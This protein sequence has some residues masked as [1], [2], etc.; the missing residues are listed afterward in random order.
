[1]RTREQTP[2]V[3]TVAVSQSDWDPKVNG[4]RCPAL[5][6]PGTDVA[7]VF[8]AGNRVDKACYFVWRENEMI[9]WSH[10]PQPKEATILFKLTEALSTKK[11]TD[12]WKG[13]AA[14]APV[15]AALTTVMLSY[16][17]LRPSVN[18]SSGDSREPVVF[19]LS[20]PVYGECGGVTINGSVEMPTGSRRRIT[21][22]LWD[23]GDGHSIDGFLPVTHRYSQNEK[24]SAKVIAY[25]DDNETEGRTILINITN[26]NPNCQ[27]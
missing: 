3:F 18:S 13:V 15:L 17:L 2:I 27:Q 26:V 22:L 5:K 25:A 23:W 16:F 1:M 14:L 11:R 20:S 6:I 21:R 9:Q 4:W 24:Y 8:V 10:L 19:N 7:D 12:F